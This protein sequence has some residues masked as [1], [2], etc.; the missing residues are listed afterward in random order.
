M[1]LVIQYYVKLR[2]TW[3]N[4]KLEPNENDIEEEYGSLFIE[5]SD[6]ISDSES[7]LSESPVDIIKK[8]KKSIEI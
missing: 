2:I 8:T 7:D 3:D 6:S 1:T 5:N 4:H